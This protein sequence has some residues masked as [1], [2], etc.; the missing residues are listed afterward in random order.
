MSDD[1]RLDPRLKNVP[2][3][4]GYKVLEPCVLYSCLGRGGM[5]TVYRGFHLNLEL[6]VAVKV[7][8]ESLAVEEPEFVIRFQREARVAAAIN[9]PHLVRVYDVGKR[10]GV[11]YLIMEFV[12][13]ETL[14][15]RV[16]RKGPLDVAEALAII[17]DAGLGLAAAHKKG[18]VH[19]DIKP[20]NIL[21]SRQGE[22]KVA[23][24]GL[25]RAAEAVDSLATASR[26]MLGTPQYM[27]PEQ[28]E[29]TRSVG[30]AGDVYSLSATLWFLLAGR[31]AVDGG[32]ITEI[33]RRVVFEPFPDLGVQRPDLPAGIVELV[34]RAT[35]PD[36]ADRFVDAGAFAAAVEEL[37][38]AP[39]M[40]TSLVDE[41]A[42]ERRSGSSVISPPPTAKTMVRIRSILESGGLTTPVMK[43]QPA[44]SVVETRVVDNRPPSSRH[45]ALAPWRQ[46][47]TRKNA[48]LACLGV[49][50]VGLALS[51]VG[52]L[53]LF[54][55]T[56]R[57]PM[58]QDPAAWLPEK[59]LEFYFAV[60]DVSGVIDQMDRAG[61]E[62]EL[63][64]PNMFRDSSGMRPIEAMTE[65]LLGLPLRSGSD[66]ARVGLADE[67]FAFAAYEARHVFSTIRCR[68]P[69]VF[70]RE[71]YRRWS[72]AED[73]NTKER[74]VGSF[75]VID[76]FYAGNFAFH[77]RSL[78][79]NGDHAYLTTRD[80]IEPLIEF[81]E[82]EGRR[83]LAE[84][85]AF[86]RSTDELPDDRDASIFLRVPRS[87]WPGD[88]MG[89]DLV[90][91]LEVLAGSLV[92]SDHQLD[93]ELRA[94]LAEDSVLDR[95]LRRTGDS[96]M[97]R[98]SVDGTLMALEL[99]F[100]SEALLQWIETSLGGDDLNRARREMR[101]DLGVDYEDLLRQLDGRLALVVSKEVAG[102]IHPDPTR[103]EVLI[104][105]EDRRIT[106]PLGRDFR[107]LAREAGPRFTLDWPR[108]SLLLGVDGDASVITGAME[109]LYRSEDP[110]R[111][112]LVEEDG[113]LILRLDAPG[114][115]SLALRAD[116]QDDLIVVSLDG[117]PARETSSH[118][119]D[120]SFGPASDAV[121]RGYFDAP[122][123]ARWFRDVSGDQEY[124]MA[125]RY[126]RDETRPLNFEFER[127]GTRLVGR[128]HLGAGAFWK[129]I[130]HPAWRAFWAALMLG[131]AAM[132]WW[133]RR[134]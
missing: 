59:G 58:T 8:K 78:L 134:S 104:V 60:H 120:G 88:P 23:D 71:V 20:G 49:G 48:G 56:S 101:K 68:D 19:R 117:L 38:D 75:R 21:V 97:G 63:A 40:T 122:A 67:G 43:G 34:R 15:D 121:V 72:S 116:N 123:F 111:T 91:S 47:M 110:E 37:I 25:A 130:V 100:D 95:V 54:G 57:G 119:V 61:R 82:T 27:P 74:T 79:I 109:N 39:S 50:L 113:S 99:A 29:D 6:D 108:V 96:L 115:E 9:S 44:D 87:A 112:R 31:D 102:Q 12:D 114:G 46:F 81:L 18:I 4:D 33:M 129:T 35:R 128:V 5:G 53:T 64:A 69:E 45:R 125:M 66:L 126:M 77:R 93:A 52:G 107:D 28:F 80:E 133:P 76:Q 14:R 36:P 90:A 17:R 73:M 30:P 84:D 2:E 106:L 127:D 26:M 7:L 65:E 1:P 16:E 22:V 83:T 92:L 86:R 85:D 89:D 105:T 42:G 10:F 103:N 41:E 11:H 3:V 24:L 131:G 51:W 132:I 62:A 70:R 98:F 124:Q 13:G 94:T 118:N 32:S 55:S